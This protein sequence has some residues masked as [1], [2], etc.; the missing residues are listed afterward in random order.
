[1]GMDSHTFV[2]PEVADADEVVPVSSAA[3]SL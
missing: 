2:V 1:V 3:V